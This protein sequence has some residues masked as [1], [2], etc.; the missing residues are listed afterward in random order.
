MGLLRETAPADEP[1][2]LAE[3]KLHARI[4]TAADDA[5]VG[6]LIS[7]AREQ[8]E[9]LCQRTIALAQWRL[10]LDRFPSAIALPMPRVTQVISVEYRDPDGN[11]LELALDDVTLDAGSQVSNWLYPAADATWPDTWSHPNG[12]VVVY[13]SGWAPADVPL[14]IKQWILMAV[15]AGYRNR[16]ALV[17]DRAG[18]LELPR[19]FLDGLLDPWRVPHA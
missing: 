2:T 4:D 12:V 16:E 3:A 1:V 7:A 5:L 9:S 10:T 11:L 19:N 18:R 14:A 17:D 15:A 6:M 13:E 8:A